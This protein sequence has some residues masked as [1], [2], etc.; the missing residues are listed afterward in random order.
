MLRR[1]VQGIINF[2]RGLFGKTASQEPAEPSRSPLSD[3]E[4]EYYFLQLLDGVHQ[5]WTGVKVERFFQVLGDRAS[6]DHWIAWLHRFDQARQL[7]GRPQGELGQRLVALSQV[8]SRHLATVAGEIGRKLC[9]Q[10]G[11]STSTP[12]SAPTPTH[13][14]AP[15]SD[16]HSSQSQPEPGLSTPT[17]EHQAQAQRWM[18]RALEQLNQENNEAALLGFD[19]VLDL[20]PQNLRALIYRGD[21]LAEL[22][23]FREALLAY[24]QAVQL[25]ANSAEAWSHL[26]DLQHEMK[27]PQ[28]ALESWDKAL[29]INPDDIQT[30]IHRGVALGLQL[31]R[32]DDALATW[33]KALEL[34]RHDSDIWFR[35]GVALASLERWQE[36]IDSWDRALELNPY[37]RDAWI[38]KGVALQKLGRYEEAIEANNRA[39]GLEQ[40]KQPKAASGDL[41]A[42]VLEPDPNRPRDSATDAQT[43]EELY[44]QAQDQAQTQNYHAALRFLERAIALN[45]NDA[46]LWRERSL[47]YQALEQFEEVLSACDRLLD[48][49]AE[50]LQAYR[51]RA[52]TL[53]QLHRWEDANSTWDT[54]LEHQPDDRQ[55]WMNKGIVLQKLGRYAEA[56]EAN[57][58]A[59]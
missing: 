33:D 55:A 54:I 39:L 23:R 30:W 59:I 22:K 53:Q 31:Q 52:Q 26:G 6:D 47:N 57:K 43:L 17:E 16:P 21:A 41:K 58:R 50:D 49:D 4:C 48:L 5:G 3:S 13:D 37:F 2:F 10:A 42:S 32:W 56:I 35:R 19:R 14:S 45:P 51:L 40:G 36:A 9:D 27:R 8:S 15:P 28:A 12:T 46:R 38:N 34:D 44:R 29:A 24:E 18:E 1:I 25:D 20:D 7:D 11:V